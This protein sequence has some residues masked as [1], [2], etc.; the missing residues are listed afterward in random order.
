MRRRDFIAGIAGSTAAWPLALRAQQAVLSRRNARLAVLIAADGQ[1][2]LQ[3]IQEQLAQHGWIAGRNLQLEY[4]L[5]EGDE[6]KIRTYASELVR[7]RPD[8]VLAGSTAAVSALLRETQTIP[9]V[10]ATVS[11]PVAS[12]FVASLARPG[13]NATGFLTFEASMGGKW[14]QLVKELAPEINRAVA[15]YNPQTTARAGAYFFDSFRDGA[16]KLSLDAMTNPIVSPQEIEPMFASLANGPRT[17]LIVLPGPFVFAQRSALASAGLRYKFPMI[18]PYR[19]SAFAGGLASYGMD[20]LEEY[21]K[22]AIYVGR[23]LLGEEP[24]D[25]PVQTP[26]KLELV[27]NLNAAKALGLAIPPMLLAR[28]DEVI[29]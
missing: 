6:A 18:N 26:T 13:G 16:K 15:I 17:G 25:L 3:A 23:I 24:A 9:I 10:F 12:G 4:R 22:A 11:D 7:W 27:I 14:L 19:D 2:R 20:M 8:V 29:E 28:A 1:I 21:R 5:T